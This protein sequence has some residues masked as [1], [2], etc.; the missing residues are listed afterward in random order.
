M[1]EQKTDSSADINQPGFLEIVEGHAIECD[2]TTIGAEQSHH[3]FQ[4]DAFAGA[5]GAENDSCGSSRNLEI[6]TVDDGRTFERLGYVTKTDKWFR[7]VHHASPYHPRAVNTRSTSPQIVLKGRIF[8][9]ERRVWTAKDGTEQCREIVRHPGAV[10]IVPVLN[11]DHVI[12]V[13]V[14]RAAVDDYL[15]EFP[16]GKLESGEPPLEAARRELSEETGYSAGRM[17]LL[18]EYLTSPGF[19]DERMHAFVAKDLSS[20]EAHPEEGEDVEARVFSV[21]EIEAMIDSGLL[22]DGKSLA[23]WL[24]WRRSSE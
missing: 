6:E 22:R 15:W 11:D 7:A 12:L 17:A 5:T 20:G 13:R 19:A 18:G 16:A 4:R 24:L 9:V 10:T 23:A 8:A 21:T 1:L 14:W 3:Q 2:F